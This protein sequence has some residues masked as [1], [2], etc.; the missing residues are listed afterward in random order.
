MNNLGVKSREPVIGDS[1]DLET[2]GRPSSQRRAAAPRA[3]SPTPRRRSIEAPAEQT[4]AE[5]IAPFEASLA[6]AEVA[7]APAQVDIAAADGPNT[8]N[9]GYEARLAEREE[10]V[11]S[12]GVRTVKI[13]GQATPARRRPAVQIE[14]YD[15]HPDRAAQWALFLGVF[16]VVVAIVTG[17]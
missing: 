2:Y 7:A 17:S 14:R 6:R 5:A 16:M 15:Q 3:K 8:D 4:R 11:R 13:R 10:A 1:F 9:A 12:A